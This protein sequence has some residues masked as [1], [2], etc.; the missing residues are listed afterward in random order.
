MVFLPLLAGLVGMT[1]LEFWYTTMAVPQGDQLLA[2]AQDIVLVV[3]DTA[4]AY[5]GLHHR[6]GHSWHMSGHDLTSK[7]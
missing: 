1:A 6:L 4:P 5:L 7:L 3:M 2:V